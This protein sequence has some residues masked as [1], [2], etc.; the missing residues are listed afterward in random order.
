M[1]FELM[2]TKAFLYLLTTTILWGFNFHFAKVM[3][4]EVG[5]LEAG[6]WRYFLGAIALLVLA[7]SGLPSWEE[8]KKNSKGLLLVGVLTLFGFNVFFFLGLQTSTAIN[9][10]LIITINPILTIICSHLILKTA[11]ERQHILGAFISIFGVLFL[12]LKGNLLGINALDFNKGDLLLVLCTLLF[13][14]QNVWVKKYGSDMSN[15]NFT[16]FTNL[17][18]CLCF[19]LVM[20]FV[21]MES[22]SSLSGKFWFSAIGIGVFGTAVAYFLWN[23]G[24]K[25]SSPN[26]AGIMVNVV[27]LSAATVSVFLGEELRFYHFIS[28]ILIILGLLVARRQFPIFDRDRKDV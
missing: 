11:L 12:I 15:R 14:L 18:A 6:F 1:I 26:Q 3:L 5:F 9:G 17:L 8:I 28:A 24:I 2:K 10:A 16:F 22:L 13:A 27:P 19:A 20:P 23:E 25:R 4:D 21:G 7:F